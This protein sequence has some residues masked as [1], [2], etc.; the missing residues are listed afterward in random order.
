MNSWVSRDEHFLH[1]CQRMS[2]PLVSESLNTKLRNLNWA[3]RI[4][5]Y[6]LIGANRTRQ[7]NCHCIPDV[8]FN[9]QLPFV[10]YSF[11]ER[12]FNIDWSTAKLYSIRTR[13][14]QCYPVICQVWPFLSCLKFTSTPTKTS[15]CPCRTRD[16]VHF[17]YKYRRTDYITNKTINIK[18]MLFLRIIIV[19]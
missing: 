11:S 12:L 16:A 5:N 7:M 3:I 8:M 13:S 15:Q 4:G 19:V 17:H 6:L 10:L 2:W 9:S 1:A 14:N 18:N